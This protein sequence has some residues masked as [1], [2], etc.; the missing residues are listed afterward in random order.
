MRDVP[1]PDCLPQGLEPPAKPASK[2]AKPRAKPS[3]KS[4]AKPAAQVAAKSAAKPV[5]GAAIPV[6]HVEHVQLFKVR[7]PRQKKW[8][9]EP[10]YPDRQFTGHF[11]V[12]MPSCLHVL[13]RVRVLCVL[14]GGKGTITLGIF[15]RGCEDTL[16]RR[17]SLFE[18]LGGH[19]VVHLEWGS[20]QRRGR[21][22]VGHQ[23]STELRGV[24]NPNMTQY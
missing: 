22:R 8:H 13:L 18:G 23:T 24:G 9:T 19:H 7:Y 14:S 10:V 1:E 3:T 12:H 2:A 15:P 4:A 16:A 6:A 5:A 11:V 17:R 21:V 20:G